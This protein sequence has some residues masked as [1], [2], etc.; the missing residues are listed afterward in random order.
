MTPRYAHTQTGTSIFVVFGV[1][2][3]LI[4]AIVIPASVSHGSP[5]AVEL[6]ALGVVLLIV[7]IVM[8]L[9]SRLTIIVDDNRISW[10]FGAGWPKFDQPLSEVV[11]AR[12]V[13]NSIVY[14][15]GIRVIPKGMLYNVSGRGAVEITRPDGKL[16]RLGSDEPEKLLAAIQDA[17]RR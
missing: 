13:S 7:F 16:I 2:V 15:Y 17:A 14:G 9:F 5:P 6:V 12:T 10:R 8:L 1:V 4:S 11:S 3:A